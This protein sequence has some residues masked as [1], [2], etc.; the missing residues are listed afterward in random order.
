MSLHAHLSSEG[1]KRILAL[2]GGGIRGALTLGYLQRMEELLRLQHGG[3]VSFRL[4]DYFDLIGG[5][6]TGSIIASCLAIGMSVE[7]IREKYFQ[8]GERI[9]GKKY[10]WWDPVE[11]KKFIR[12]GYDVGPMQTELHNVFGDITMG[13]DKIQTG[14]CIVTKRAD[15]NSVWPIINH[16][17]GKYFD[18]DLGKNRD[19]LLWKA[20][21]A[22]SAAPSYFLAQLIDVGGGAPLAAF[23]DGGVSMAN[24][25]SF[26]LLMVA[27]LKGF[28]FKWRLGADNL[29]LVSVGTGI[30]EMVKLPDII[31]ENTMLDWARQVPY[32]LMQDASWQNQA[33]LQWLSSTPTACIIDGE[34]G[35]MKEDILSSDPD[36]KGL[37]SYLRYNVILARRELSRLM[38]KEYTEQDVLQVSDMSNTNKRFELYDIGYAA[39]QANILKEHFPDRFNCKQNN[40]QTKPAGILMKDTTLPDI[41]IVS[42][43]VHDAWRRQKERQ[44]FHAPIACPSESHRD[45]LNA[46]KAGEGFDPS[47][48]E[49][50]AQWCPQ[51]H[52]NLYPFCELSEQEKEL[53]RATVR[54]VYEGIR[55]VS[56]GAKVESGFG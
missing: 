20:V 4:C 1:P 39:G 33:I 38:K 37:L 35:D 8:L 14:L 44:G 12:A 15:T 55:N 21:M 26:Q 23:I 13:S 48:D 6:S 19:I 36:S 27:T 51:C 32:M 42:E 34:I 45:Y 54:A 5:T 56:S 53:D 52:P 18:S 22:S 47:I 3:D 24:N 7:Q 50:K 2:D 9:F 40:Q 17:G 16:P 43:M 46:K 28:P 49:R 41:E 31:A 25:P 30:T 11:W 29:L 10:R